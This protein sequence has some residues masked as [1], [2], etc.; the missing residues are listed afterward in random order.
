[1]LCSFSVFRAPDFSKPVDFTQVGD[2]AVLMQS[3]DQVNHPVCNFSKKFT[4]AERH[5]VTE[6]ELFAIIIPLQHFEVYVPAYGPKVT[7]FSDHSPLQ[8]LK[9]EF[10]PHPVE[11]IVDVKHIK[12][13][14]NVIVDCSSKV[15]T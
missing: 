5:S 14:D 13:A 1:M 12:R 15:G 6:Q 2:E 10:A 9:K 11:P 8:F 7:V 3:D 4:A